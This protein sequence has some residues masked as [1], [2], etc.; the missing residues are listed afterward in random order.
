MT[1]YVY[2]R[3]GSAWG[4]LADTTLPTNIDPNLAGITMQVAPTGA[5]GSVVTG[6]ETVPITEPAGAQQV[7]RYRFL[8]TEAG[9]LTDQTVT[10]LNA[11]NQEGLV[12]YTAAGQVDGAYGAYFFG[13]NISGDRSHYLVP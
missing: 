13:L 12:P 4:L 6:A 11:S 8:T 1:G 9:G 7:F 2:S 3:L 10:G 5:F